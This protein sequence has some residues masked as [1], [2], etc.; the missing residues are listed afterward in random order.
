MQTNTLSHQDN[1]A[2]EKDTLYPHSF[3]NHDNISSAFVE[4][5]ATLESIQDNIN[6]IGEILKSYIAG[7]YGFNVKITIDG[8]DIKDKLYQKML[9]DYRYI[10]DERVKKK[11]EEYA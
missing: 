4:E 9:K 3:L 6:Y 8:K 11:I 7:D 1:I 10:K 5:L 2:Q